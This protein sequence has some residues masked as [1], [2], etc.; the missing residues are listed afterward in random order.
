MLAVVT[1]FF[2][3]HGLSQQ[4]E[5]YFRFAEAISPA[6]LFTVEM[7][8]SGQFIISGSFRI[9]GCPRTQILWQKERL[10]N[11]GIEQL[12]DCFD[13]IAWV[14]C[15][16]QFTNP[17]WYQMTETVLER[18]P[19]VQ[20]FQQ[21]HWLNNN[22][23]IEKSRPSSASVNSYSQADRSHPGFAWAA[24]RNQIQRWGGL[25]DLDITGGGDAWM[26]HAFLGEHET[27]IIQSASPMLRSEG[28]RWSQRVSQATGGKID[29]IP[30]DV[31]HLCHG[32]LSDR[33][34]WDRFLV[35]QKHNYDPGSDVKIADNGAWKWNS[36]KEDFHRDVASR[37]G[38]LNIG[39]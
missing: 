8:F 29:E 19:V 6:P 25:F 10:L 27:P 4:I 15:D 34:Y 23:S 31:L 39:K 3:S 16:I 5:N 38:P 7:S 13:K 9:H 37:F 30:G 32:P 14:D 33:G 28:L 18:V 35:L 17:K 11:W 21:C 12:P 36:A 1:C 20:L 2:N 22:D 24:R 26:A